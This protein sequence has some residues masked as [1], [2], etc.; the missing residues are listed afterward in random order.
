MVNKLSGL[1]KRRER[2]SEEYTSTLNASIV[3]LRRQNPMW[4][5]QTIGTIVGV[6]RERVRQVL[7]QEDLPTAAVK[8][9][10]IIVLTCAY[11]G[12]QFERHIRQHDR[13]MARGIK[14]TFCGIKCRRSGN[15][16]SAAK[17]RATRTVCING[18]ALTP[19][20]TYHGDKSPRCRQCRTDYGKAYY[21]A[22]KAARQAAAN[23][24]ERLDDN[25]TGE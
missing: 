11:C 6:T 10:P 2:V 13:N 1:K 20:N 16:V 24:A 12:E 23:G 21:Q 22:R 5:L 25:T 15:I 7:K 3:D 18:H 8:E 4:T 9:L 14:T 17:V 19:A